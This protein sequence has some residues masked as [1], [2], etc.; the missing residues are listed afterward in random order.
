MHDELRELMEKV[1]N[2]PAPSPEEHE[3]QSFDWAYG[4]LAASTNHKP[5]KAAFWKLASER[6]WSVARFEEWAKGREWLP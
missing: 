1:K 2:L 6:G 4:N 3:M 5:S